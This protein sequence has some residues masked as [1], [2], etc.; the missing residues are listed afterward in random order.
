MAVYFSSLFMFCV[1]N[2]LC[3]DFSTCLQ[4]FNGVRVTICVSAS[5]LNN[6]AAYSHNSIASQETIIVLLISRF[7]H[8][9]CA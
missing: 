9:S 4:E 8:H 7:S 1:R 3:D 6:K 2:C 5:N